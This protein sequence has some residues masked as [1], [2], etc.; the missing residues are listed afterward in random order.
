M[1]DGANQIAGTRDVDRVTITVGRFAVGDFFDGNAY[2]KDPRADFMNCSLWASAAYDFPADL[3]GF[4]RGAV[5]ELNRKDWTFRAGL[6]QVPT[7]PNSDTLVFRT[8]G[9]AVEW[10]QRHA[11]LTQPGALRAGLFHNRGNTGNYRQA[12]ALAAL[13]P[14]LDINEAML[15]TRRDRPKSGFYVNLE[16]V[17]SREIGLFARAS[18]D[19]GRNEIL[20]FTDI[21]SSVSGGVSLA[22]RLWG[23]EGDRIGIGS[24]VNGLSQAHRDFLAA[25]GGLGC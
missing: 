7:G 3:P 13:D 9:V 17:L 25:G 15:S 23:R 19:D 2:A 18:W 8:G 5:V 21:D 24:A 1:E 6:F 16:Q 22:G 11:L 14:S 10:E 12:L 4:T 20:S